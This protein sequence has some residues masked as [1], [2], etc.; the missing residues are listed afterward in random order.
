[1]DLTYLGAEITKHEKDPV[2]GYVTVWGKLTGPDLDLDQQICDPGWLA[3]AVPDWFTSGAN[4]RLSHTSTAVGKGTELEQQ[5]SDWWLKSL[6]VDKDACEKVETEVLTAYSIGIKGAR[7]IKDSQAPGGRIVGGKIV[8]SSIVDRPSNPTTKFVL[9]KSVDGDKVIP[10]AEWAPTEGDGNT[11]VDPEIVKTAPLDPEDPTD[12]QLEFI[13]AWTAKRAFSDKERAAL[14]AKG[15][16]MP[17]GGFPIANVEDLKNAIQAI[18]RAKDP[19]AAKKHIIARAA[20]LGQSKL[21]PDTWKAVFADLTKAN[22]DE[23][24][25]DPA[26]FIQVRNGLALLMQAELDE[27]MKGEDEACDLS[28]LL[29]SLQ[30]FLCFWGHEAAEG[31]DPAPFSHLNPQGDVEMSMTA[32]GVSAD[33]IKAAMADDATDEAKAAPLAELKKNL[34]LDPET[35]NATIGDAVKAALAEPLGGLQERLATV[36]TMAAP[37]GYPGPART[38]TQSDATKAAAIDRLTSEADHYRELASTVHD[39]EL[40]R[41]YRQKAAQLDH[42]LAASRG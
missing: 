13:A 41:G 25:H 4:I 24:T 40:A 21:I 30:T 10:A 26:L 31:E 38:R 9:A 39:S 11:A 36:E 23:W 32:L 2:T 28:Q 20:A 6:I 8:E 5:G 33:T 7:A 18:G 34:G 14:A 17:G 42:D 12:E 27:L 37:G 16:A 3:K 15:Q 19:A 29:C 35:I 22:G 1:M